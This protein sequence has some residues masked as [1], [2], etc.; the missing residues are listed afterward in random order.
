MKILLVEDDTLIS[1]TLTK[2]LTANQYE[3][4][5]AVDGETGL[6]MAIT[7]EYDLILLDL[8]LPKLDGISLCQ[9]LRSQN[10]AKPILLLTAKD[11]NSDLVAGLD[12][13]ADDYVIKP[14]NPETLLARIRA[15]WRRSG[16]SDLDSYSALTWGNLSVNLNAATVTFGSTIISL[17]ATEYKLLELFLHN[18]N[19]IFTRSAILDRLWEFDD[20]PTERAIN[21]HIKDLRKKLKESGLT[22][23][24]I[25]TI[26]GM[27]Y[28]LKPNPKESHTNPHT[29]KTEKTQKPKNIAAVN[30]VIERF[31][32]SFHDQVSVL[33]AAN[34][35]M[36]EGKLDR[37]L[38]DSAKQEAHKLAGS[39]GS[40]GYPEGSKLAREIEHLL[41]NNPS[42]A[43]AEISRF[44]QL[45]TGLK[46][47]LTQ[48]PIPDKSAP[49]TPGKNYRVLVID[50]DSILTEKLLAEAEY[51][52]IR[53]KI[54][55]NLIK[56]RSRI[57][58]ATPD[59]VLLD[60]T[61]PD[62]EEDGL[63]LLR[64]LKEKLPHLPVIVFTARD[65]LANRLA[66]SR[67]GAKQFIHKPATT[68]QI[69]QAI[70]RVLPQSQTKEATVLIVDDDPVS[71]ATLSGFL[72]PWGLQVITLTKPEQ[73]WQILIATSPNLVILDLEMPL[74][75]GL[76][77]CQVI[78][79][80]SQWGDLPILVVTAH[81]DS[82]SL[83]QAF[84]AGADDFITKPVLGPELVTRVLSRIE[85]MGFHC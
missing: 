31:R 17:T 70:S 8:Q 34:T 42:L 62:T 72:N 84:A 36:V 21:T 2:L 30:R 19:R 38:H 66:V 15:L 25:Q 61:F 22:E 35:A 64:E 7:V 9:K 1:A 29:P 27:G 43:P 82:A 16:G 71:L 11:A 18:P 46:K 41:I 49:V 4:D 68:E 5:I 3:I 24:I 28:R 47:E 45:V 6:N 74:V 44:C 23:D 58:L 80:D 79:Q 20:P 40:F 83:S 78:R 77:L 32:N 75:N 13:G 48:T 60:L 57:A 65:S 33:V 52:G 37:E 14:Y 55:P 63:T 51:W 56:A 10:Y 53:L 12:A 67:L 76:E 50:D 85:R 59:V 81:T 54:A 69:F 26:Y 39:M 73:F